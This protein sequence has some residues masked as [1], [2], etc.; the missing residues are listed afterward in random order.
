MPFTKPLPAWKVCNLCGVAPR[1]GVVLPCSHTYCE[2]CFDDFGDEGCCL[3]D[4]ECFEP[5]Q[6][7]RVV[8]QL[9][10]RVVSCW[11]APN[12]CDFM[13]SPKNL[14]N[15]FQSNCDF[16]AVSCPRCKKSVLRS[17]IVAH[18]KSGCVI[19]P[20]TNN[21][22]PQ[23]LDCFQT[24]DI[25][26]A[27]V[28]AKEAL[29][30]VADN[31][32][33]LQRA[34]DDLSGNLK[35][36]TLRLAENGDTRATAADSRR[37]EQLLREI[38]MVLAERVASGRSHCKFHVSDEIEQLKLNFPAAIQRVSRELYHL[39][40]PR[41][42]EWDF[43][44]PNESTFERS[45][46]GSVCLESDKWYA[47]GYCVSQGVVLLRR[48]GQFNVL[49]GL[50]VHKGLHDAEVGWPFSKVC[51]LSI[52]HPEDWERTVSV[53]ID[54]DDCPGHRAFQRPLRAKNVSFGTGIVTTKAR[55]EEEGFF[56][57]S[58]MLR[59]RMEVMP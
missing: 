6:V 18:L 38:L 23:T 51:V 34:V 28:D 46:R 22:R 55:L 27:Y 48:G 44:W 15:H 33:C 19:S 20:S 59:L 11:N 35:A 50:T 37:V 5:E 58:R 24:A 36:L 3:I 4:N 16:H 56:D 26:R 8:F 2:L 10:T 21:F 45:P 29:G 57:D 40:V 9:T 53:E 17:N 47:Y 14:R 42:F 49:L 1:I 41:M 13:G 32:T 54:A 39:F 12:G 43:K 52:V 25:Q 30:K 31:E 7:W